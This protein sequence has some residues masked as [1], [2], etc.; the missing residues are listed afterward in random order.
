MFYTVLAF[1]LRDPLFFVVFPVIVGTITFKKHFFLSYIYDSI[2]A[3][4]SHRIIVERLQKYI[5]FIPI[6]EVRLNYL[7][8]NKVYKKKKK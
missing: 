1:F 2:I 7:N 3:L 6:K 4:S 5:N 8:F